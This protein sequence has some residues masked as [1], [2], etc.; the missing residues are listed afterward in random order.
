[1]YMPCTI[2][3]NSGR[4]YAIGCDDECARRK[5]SSPRLWRARKKN[6]KGL[7][8][9]IIDPIFNARKIKFAVLDRLKI[10]EPQIQRVHV[11]IN[12]ES[13]F[14]RLI[15][16]RLNNFVVANIKEKE[17]KNKFQLSLIANIIN[18]AQH[19]RLYFAKCRIDSRIILY[20]NYPVSSNYLNR[21]HILDY[22]SYYNHKMFHNDECQFIVDSIQDIA[23]LLRK[24]VAFINE[25]YLING[26][27]VESSLVPLIMEENVFNDYKDTQKIIISDSKYDFQYVNYGYTVIESAKDESVLVTKDNVMDILKDRNNIKSEPTVPATLLPFVTCLLGDRYRNI[28]KL[29]GVGL[30]TIIKVINKGLDNHT[31]TENTVNVDMLAKIITVQYQERFRNNYLC[32]SLS[33]QLKEVT[34]LDISLIR[35]QI[36][37]KFDDRTLRQ[38]NERYFL[39]CPIMMIDTKT[40]QM[41]GRKENSPL[42]WTKKE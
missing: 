21:K 24:L 3:G 8:C 9:M 6:K 14:N 4:L 29:A 27:N 10:I 37:D 25:V 41:L 32:T 35:Q 36:V 1:M 23:S 39:H 22:R 17:D 13:V 30:S 42:K 31:I 26:G 18:L 11:Y 34:P 12:L 28:P 7:I 2:Y 5:V 33:Y 38:M 20:W 16:S 15:Q 19:Y 40:D